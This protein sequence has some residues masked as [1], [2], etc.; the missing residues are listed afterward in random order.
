MKG[1]I[2]GIDAPLIKKSLRW[3]EPFG[4]GLHIRDTGL[5][6]RLFHW[7]VGY[8]LNRLNN[9][10]YKLLLPETY[11]LELKY[12][13]LPLTSK[14]LNIS[15]E[16]PDL[17]QMKFKTVTDVVNNQVYLADPINKAFMQRMIDSENFHLDKDHYFAD[18]GYNF[19]HTL[20]E[21]SPVK[22]RGLQEITFRHKTLE[23]LIKKH[24]HGCIGIHIRRGQGVHKTVR[25]LKTLPK[26]IRDQF[27]VNKGDQNYKFFKDRLYYD[28]IDKI[29]EINPH[30]K[31]YI[32]CDL[33]TDQYSYFVDD[34]GPDTIVVKDH[35]IQEALAYA[36]VISPLDSFQSNALINVVDLF[37]LAFCDF[38]I[39]SPASTWSDMAQ[40]Y[41]DI[42]YGNIT[43]PLNQLV[44]STKGVLKKKQIL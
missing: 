41:R 3:S 37:S 39:K 28:Y 16:A 19:V 30:Q 2:E 35:F 44:R 43:Q 25:D 6:N 1:R 34:Y 36:D 7:E 33:P 26:P 12:L 22:K 10:K 31:F 15:G 27:K 13:N 14:W 18:F 5:C 20:H 38:L 42:P 32:S 17:H 9:Y 24:V 23:N 40:I 11:W 21:H 29:L 4:G 8:E